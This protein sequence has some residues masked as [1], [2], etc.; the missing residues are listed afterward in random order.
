VTPAQ[1]ENV[2]FAQFNELHTKRFIV[3]ASYSETFLT[4]LVFLRIRYTKPLCSSATGAALTNTS[5]AMET[6]KENSALQL[7]GQASPAASHRGFAQKLP[8]LSIAKRSNAS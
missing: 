5:E 4:P 3:L 1:Y 6:T 2:I 7:S 8:V